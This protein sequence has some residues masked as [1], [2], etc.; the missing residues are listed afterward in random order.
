DGVR[1]LHRLRPAAL[2]GTALR[3]SPWAAAP[4][5]LAAILGVQV[6]RG[7]QSDA[8]KKKEHDYWKQNLATWKD[9]PQPEIVDEVGDL[10]L[11]PRQ[12]AFKTKGTFRLSNPH[13][14]PLRQFALT[15]GPHWGEVA[16]TLDGQEVKP[17]NRTHLFVFTPRAP[18]A[19]GAAA[20]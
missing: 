3:L 20:T 2:W 13:D 16:W 12:S 1:I 17:E 15:G 8:A 4:A 5:I 11:D 10:R 18:L 9:V 14:A 7:F 6:G 19:P